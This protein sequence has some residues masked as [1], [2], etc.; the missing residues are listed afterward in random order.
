MEPLSIIP[1]SNRI[2][3]RYIRKEKGIRDNQFT[4]LS[5]SPFPSSPGGPSLRNKQIQTNKIK[6]KNIFSPPYT[7]I[8]EKNNKVGIATHPSRKYSEYLGASGVGVQALI[9]AKI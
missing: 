9:K 4:I 5:L 1:L 8:L 3:N 6:V 7:R 2:Q